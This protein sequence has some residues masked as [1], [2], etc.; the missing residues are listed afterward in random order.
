MR[1]FCAARPAKRQA[2]GSVVDLHWLLY[3]LWVLGEAVG[4]SAKRYRPD[5]LVAEWLRSGLQIRVR[6]F[7]SGR[8][9]QPSLP[10][11][12]RFGRLRPKAARATAVG[13]RRVLPFAKRLSFVIGPQFGGQP[14]S[15]VAQR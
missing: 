15:L 14:C 12:R 7:D 9:L 3:R 11:E 6:R 8:G 10:K 5:G 13:Q 4:Q 2:S 1:G